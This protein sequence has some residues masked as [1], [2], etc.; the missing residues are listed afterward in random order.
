VRQQHLLDRHGTVLCTLKP[1]NVI[2]AAAA[3]LRLRTRK[4]EQRADPFAPYSFHR[5]HVGKAGNVRE[6]IDLAARE[7]ERGLASGKRST[8]LLYGAAELLRAALQ[9]LGGR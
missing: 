6:L 4:G 3:D 1:A 2:Q 7:R 9:S 5:R 8:R